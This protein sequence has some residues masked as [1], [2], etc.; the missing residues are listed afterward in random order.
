V[1]VDHFPELD[2]LLLRATIIP[3]E[4]LFTSRHKPLLRLQ[5]RL[6]VPL[7]LIVI[8]ILRISKIPIRSIPIPIPIMLYPRSRNR[9]SSRSIVIIRS[10]CGIIVGFLYVA[11]TITP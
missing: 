10:G 7:L 2:N 6:K 11:I 9:R 5:T 3:L 1:L 4:I 8:I